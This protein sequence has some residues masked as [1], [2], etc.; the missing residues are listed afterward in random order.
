MSQNNWIFGLLLLGFVIYI[1][2]RGELPQYLA[3]FTP[4]AK[5]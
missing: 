3:V 5:S 4:K 1:T 2:S